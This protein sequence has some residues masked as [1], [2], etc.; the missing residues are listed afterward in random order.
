MKRKAISLKTKL[1][2][3]LACLLP[4]DERDRLRAKGS[5][6]DVI[7]LFHFDHIIPHADNGSD[8]WFNLDPLLVDA[9]REKTAKVDV[10]RIAKGKRIRRKEAEH[11]QRMREIMA[12]VMADIIPPD[13]QK[14]PRRRSRIPSRPF[15]R[16]RGPEKPQQLVPKVLPRRSL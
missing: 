1:A 12:D 10:P 4:Q 9:H 2:A 8:C 11:H 6:D 16:G 3:A 14:R 7:S 13:T 15:N 5:E